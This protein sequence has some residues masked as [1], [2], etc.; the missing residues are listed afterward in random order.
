[1][2]HVRPTS[3]FEAQSLS[4]L[5]ASRAPPTH[6]Y[7]PKHLT[8]THEAVKPKTRKPHS[9]R[10]V[11]TKTSRPHQKIAYILNL[12][13]EAPNPGALRSPRSETLKL[14][15]YLPAFESSSLFSRAS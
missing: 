8:R 14:T 5:P 3:L 15:A 2:N 7:P 1:M 9:P 4:R 12:K 11:L 13:A 10:P 6:P